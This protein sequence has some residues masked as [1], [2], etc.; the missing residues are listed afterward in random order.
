MAPCFI[1]TEINEKIYKIEGVQWLKTMH[2]PDMKRE[3]RFL[4]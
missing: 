1:Y 3:V 2:T 4:L